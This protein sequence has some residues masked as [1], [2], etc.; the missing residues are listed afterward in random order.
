MISNNHP[1]ASLLV[2]Y[3]HVT[4]FHSGRDLTLNLITESFWIINAKSLIC[5]V[6]KSYLY[7]NRIRNHPKPPVM[8]D[9]PPERLS[10]FLPPFFCGVDYFR[11]LTIK[12][13]KGTRC[14]S[15]T[16]KQDGALFTCMIT[17]AVYLELTGDMSTDSFILALHRF[18]ARRGHPKSIQSDNGSKFIGAKRKLKD[19]LSK[20]DQKKIINELNE[21]RI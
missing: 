2:F 16:A 10:S 7:C 13:N 15:G 11:P 20:L 19:A 18:K 4:N 17:R 14:T 1:I 9:L 8:S 21:N 12:L 6:L 3:I 5:K